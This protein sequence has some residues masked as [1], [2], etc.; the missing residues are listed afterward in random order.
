MKKI[1]EEHKDMIIGSVLT[2]VLIGMVVLS[3]GN[4][5]SSTAA[6]VSNRNYEDYQDGEIL[7][8][9]AALPGP[10]IMTNENRQWIAG[11]EVIVSQA[12]TAQD[13]E[14]AELNIKVEQITD[15]SEQDLTVLYD[16]L[17]GKVVFQ[18]PGCYYFTL[19][20]MD[21]QNKVTM[22]K[23]PLIIDR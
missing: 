8:E 4:I 13:H 15:T 16:P 10:T 18:E 20:T 7:K 12:F 19:R 2:G 6:L 14:G 21:D 23:R 17:T 11:E 5:G 9:E 3:L 22:V 1:F